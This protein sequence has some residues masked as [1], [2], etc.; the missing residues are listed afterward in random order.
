WGWIPEKRP[1]A[2]FNAAGWAGCMALPRVL[3]LNANNDLEMRIAPQAESLRRRML[4]SVSPA[5]PSEAR[6]KVLAA[7]EI[8]RVAG[9]L[10]WQTATGPFSL[11]IADDAGPWWSLKAETSGSTS[12]LE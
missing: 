10:V 11:T 6:A 3:S 5:T 2:E 8:A 12:G 4:A 7:I 9:E 1:E